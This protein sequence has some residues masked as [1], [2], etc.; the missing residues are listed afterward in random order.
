MLFCIILLASL[1]A[2]GLGIFAFGLFPA[3]VGC[4]IA[5]FAVSYVA[6]VLLYLLFCALVCLFVDKKKPIEREYPLCRGLIGHLADFV[7][8]H[9]GVRFEAEG[10][11][12]IPQD[13][14]FLMVCNHLGAFDPI[15]M[16]GRLR[17]YEISCISK[18]SNMKIPVLAR[19]A[20]GMGYLP[21]DR[22]NDRNALKTILQA[23][24]YLKRDV[25]SICIYPEGTRSRDGKL[26]PFHAGS[27]KIAQRG[28]VPLVIAC[29]SGSDRVFKNFP[30]RP[31]RVRLRV[32]ET[33]PAERV[34]AMSTQELSDYSRKL[35]EGNL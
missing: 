26:L 19:L 12:K 35:I 4:F 14:R 11:D 22:E 13:R 18:P 33:I 28:N 29:I 23:A 10:T 17:K 9:L 15:C 32:L 34:K 30:L 21:I 20:Y 5:V 27:F 16:M 2:A 1:L 8:L 6:L 31:T 25:C 24:D 7:M 3:T